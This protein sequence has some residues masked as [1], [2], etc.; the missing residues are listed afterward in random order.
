MFLNDKQAIK[1]LTCFDSVSPSG[2]D[3]MT[4]FL[5]SV[6][7]QLQTQDVQVLISC[8]RLGTI[9]MLIDITKFQ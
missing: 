7:H 1:L 4:L 3:T 2:K 9:S 8:F 5:L 6:G